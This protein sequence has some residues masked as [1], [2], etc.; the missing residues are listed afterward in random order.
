MIVDSVSL[1]R[2]GGM[3]LAG[4]KF[5]KEILVQGAFLLRLRVDE[6]TAEDWGV[7]RPAFKD[8][9]HGRCWLGRSAARGLG[10]VRLESISIPECPSELGERIRRD[11]QAAAPAAGS[12]RA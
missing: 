8:L 6:P 7:L 12:T 5:D 2:I 4:C 1:D 10:R 3:A 9:L 11:L